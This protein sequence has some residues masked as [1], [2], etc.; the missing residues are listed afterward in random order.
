VPY[1][2]VVVD[3]GSADADAVATGVRATPCARLV[4]HGHQGYGAARNAGTRAARGSFVCFT[5]DDCEPAPDWLSQL[6]SAWTDGARIVAGPTVVALPPEAGAIASQ[7][8]AD[9]LARRGRVPFAATSNVGCDARLAREVPFDSGFRYA[10]EDRDWCARL[11]MAGQE[12]VTEPGAVVFHRPNVAAA[13]FVGRHFRYGRGSHQYRRHHPWVRQPEALSFYLGLVR[14]GFACGAA[15]G[16]LVGAAQIL[17]ALGFAWDAVASRS[18]PTRRQ[19][20][21]PWAPS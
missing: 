3:D 15:V 12:I 2:V 4:R 21:A 19:A 8:V 16:A 17:T 13:A 20:M 10:S 11:T 1:E 5:D 7:L 18:R 14:S 6:T 9:A